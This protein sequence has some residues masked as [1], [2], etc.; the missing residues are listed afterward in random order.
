[1]IAFRH[2]DPRFPFLWENASQPAGRWHDAGEGPVHYFADTPTGAWAEFL[3]HE[4]IREVEDLAGV[5]RAIWAIE[6]PAAPDARPELRDE[7]LGGGPETYPE[8]RREAARLRAD[9]ASGLSAIS[10]ALASEGAT[11]WI[12]DGGL[13]KGPMRA[14]EVIVLFGRRSDLIGWPVVLDGQPPDE[15]LERVRQF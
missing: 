4:E 6:I 1:M 9:G 14:G 3:R 11:G 2:A 13:R 12:V 5:R 7:T 8:C 15:V 10:A